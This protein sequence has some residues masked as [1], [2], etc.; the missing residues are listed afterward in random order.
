M[1]CGF[2]GTAGMAIG[3]TAAASASLIPSIALTHLARQL[4]EKLKS[5]VPCGRLIIRPSEVILCTLP[6]LLFTLA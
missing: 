6:F 4:L 5:Y 1:K 3:T 2:L